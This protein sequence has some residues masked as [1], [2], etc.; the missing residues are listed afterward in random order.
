[1]RFRPRVEDKQRSCFFLY[2]R[3]E[4]GRPEPFA[5]VV[6]NEAEA[7]EVAR[8]I[9]AEVPDLEVRWEVVP[10]HGLDDETLVTGDDIF[11]ILLGAPGS[12]IGIGA[13]AA[14]AD[15]AAALASL[16]R[17]TGDGHIRYVRT[18]DWLLGNAPG[19]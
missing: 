13:F 18:G 9:Q 8:R 1:M 15:A 19:R 4:P 5:G 10:W 16:T 12:E 3:P 6:P 11:V 17:R 7:R 14:G 2:A